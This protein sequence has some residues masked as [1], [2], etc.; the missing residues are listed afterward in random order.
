MKNFRIL[1]VAALSLML[2]SGCS[3]NLPQEQVPMSNGPLSSMTASTAPASN[4][5]GSNASATGS[6]TATTS[7]DSPAAPASMPSIRDTPVQESKV[8]PGVVDNPDQRNQ[9]LVPNPAPGSAD[10]SKGTGGSGASIDGARDSVGVGSKTDKQQ[11]AESYIAFVNLIN[12]KD[13]AGACEYVKLTPA[14]GTDCL[15]A[16]DKVEIRNRTYPVG[17]KI[18]RLDNGVVKDDMATLNK[19]VFVYDG[20]KRLRDVTM[21]RPADGSE[22]WKTLL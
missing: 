11:A 8:L 21:F 19:L 3:N 22:K 12:D 9:K 13:Y 15:A 20:D 10:L 5:Q 4:T 16:M 2:L 18:D 6:P 14:Q 7:S 1:T 17:L